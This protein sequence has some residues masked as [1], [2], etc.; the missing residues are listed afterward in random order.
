MNHLISD[1][2]KFIF[3]LLFSL[4]L[5][6]DVPYFD[7]NKAYE[8]L[9]KQC[10]FGYRYPGSMEHVNMKNYFIEFLDGKSDELIVYDHSIKHPYTGEEITLFNLFSRYNVHLENRIL[11]LAH[12]DT[13]EIADM[14]KNIENHQKPILG[15]NDGA[16]GIA[17]LMHLSEILSNNPLEN[18]GVDI[19]FVD[20]EDM[21]RNGELKNFCLGTKLFSKNLMAPYPKFAICLDMVAD[22]DPEFKMEYFSYIQAEK[23]LKQIWVLANNLG[24]K[25]FTYEITNPIYD[26]HR[27]LYVETGIPSIDI[28]DFD[29]P[30]WH[31]IEDTVDK[32][33]ANTLSIVGTLMCEFL[34]RKDQNE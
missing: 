29:Y 1:M 10:D 6:I 24:F 15:A 2:K 32:C 17:I 31:T 3:I 23:E 4:A 21:G 26:D 28:I 16:S 27:A 9:V 34:Y 18:I 7:G 33:S 14:D 12:W 19:L 30:Y 8:Y 20:G 22:K 25:E 5:N 11:L 13:R